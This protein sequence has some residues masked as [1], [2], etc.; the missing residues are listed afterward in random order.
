MSRIKKELRLLREAFTK[1]EYEKAP[2]PFESSIAEVKEI[3]KS[4]ET[5]VSN[6]CKKEQHAERMVEE[7]ELFLEEN[8]MMRSE[9]I[10]AEEIQKSMLNT[11]Y[12]AFPEFPSLDLYADMDAAREIGGD[13]YDY[14]K[15][16]E[17]HI[18]IEIADVE[19]KGIPAA[20]YMTIAKSMIKIRLESGELLA[21][22]LSSVNRQL[23]LSSMQRR[24][25]TVW[26]GVLEISTGMLTYINAGHNYPVLKRKDREA[27]YVNGK[28]G[29]PLASYFSRKREMAPYKVYEL[30]LKEGDILLLYTD[31]VTETMDKDGNLY[32]EK[33][34]L[35][36]ADQY[37]AEA[38]NMKEA[39]GYV[40]R[41]VLGFAKSA[42]QN[43][44]ITILA[45]R[46]G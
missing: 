34:L 41:Q 6:L 21:E 3:K 5:I 26:I 45:L 7:Y 43:D 9:M 46:Y 8:Q 36:I 2:I 20:L 30:L 13:F 17:D 11:A 16:D 31:G 28:S 37:F 14:F 10:V 23:C 29:I 27:E 40:R 42:E 15:I 25:V 24:F 18:C 1:W 44:D 35:K 12:P 33:Q 22:V 19:G 32:G 38:H 4:V 39:V